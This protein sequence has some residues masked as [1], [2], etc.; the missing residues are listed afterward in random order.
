MSPDKTKEMEAENKELGN[1]KH[2]SW[3]LYFN[4]TL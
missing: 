3:Y 2:V 1:V 4:V